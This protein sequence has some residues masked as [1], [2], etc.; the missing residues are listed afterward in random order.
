MMNVD[1][2]GV[3]PH[4]AVVT[5]DRSQKFVARHRASGSLDEIAKKLKFPTRQRN[6]LI[7]SRYLPFDDVDQE[8]P[9]PIGVSCK[10]LTSSATTAIL[11]SGSI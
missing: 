3:C 7:V 1:F 5:P 4:V 8:W 9:E 10:R 6:R 11:R 2:D